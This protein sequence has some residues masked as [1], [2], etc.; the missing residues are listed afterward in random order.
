MQALEMSSNTRLS[1]EAEDLIS[2]EFCLTSILLTYQ[3]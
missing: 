3:L 1:E 2:Q